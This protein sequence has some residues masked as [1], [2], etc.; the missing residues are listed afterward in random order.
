MDQCQ[1]VKFA[2]EDKK[3]T[4]LADTDTALGQLHD[5][6]MLIKG[7]IVDRMVT[8]QKEEQAHADAQKQSETKE[9]E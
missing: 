2:S 5:F 8:A 4:V 3:I 7:H 9:V 6:L 1:V